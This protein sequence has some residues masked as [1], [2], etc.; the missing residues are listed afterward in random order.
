MLPAW[1][2]PND[3]LVGFDLQVDH[4]TDAE[5]SELTCPSGHEWEMTEPYP[6]LFWLTS[7]AVSY[8]R[9]GVPFLSTSSLASLATA[10]QS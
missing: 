7:R 6:A 4:G 10:L 1:M 5:R 2:L 8:E 9:R 3:F